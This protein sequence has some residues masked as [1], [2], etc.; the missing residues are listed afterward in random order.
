MLVLALCLVL[1]ELLLYSIARV[2][3]GTVYP[4]QLTRLLAADAADAERVAGRL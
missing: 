3:R 4:N 1:F 2:C